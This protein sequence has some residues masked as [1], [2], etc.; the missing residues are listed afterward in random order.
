MMRSLELTKSPV[1][2]ALDCDSLE[3]AKAWIEATSSSISTYKVGLEFF[4]AFGAP[5]IQELQSVGDFDLFLDLKL[6]DIPNTV[7]GAVQSV[8]DLRPRFLTVHASGGKQMIT[9]AVECAPDIAITAVTVL[10]SIDSAVLMEMGITL[11]PIEFATSLAINAVKAGARAL[12]CSPLEVA[13][14]RAAVGQ[15][16]TLITPGVRPSDSQLGDQLRTMTPK[17][18]IQAGSDYLVIGRPIT[19]YYKESAQAMKRRAEEICESLS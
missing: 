6:H 14:I 3:R 18:A 1:I 11:T 12:V 5:G 8:K 13:Q 9:A 4:L 7:S 10:T 2:L 15:D 16:I 19:S 17:D